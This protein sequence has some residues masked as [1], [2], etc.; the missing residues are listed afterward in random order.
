M[1]NSN[2][3]IIKQLDAIITLLQSSVVESEHVK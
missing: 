2:C 3:K 1:N